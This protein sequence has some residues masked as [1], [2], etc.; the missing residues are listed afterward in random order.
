MGGIFSSSKSSSVKEI[1]DLQD[2]EVKELKKRLVHLDSIDRNGDGIITREELSQWMKQQKTDMDY[3][4]RKVEDQ[5][6]AKYQK[7]LIDKDNEIKE[8]SR[9]VQ[10]LKNIN[11]MLETQKSKVIENYAVSGGGKPR[12]LVK[13]KSRLDEVSK[14]RVDEFVEKI[15]ADENVN[16]KYLPDF[17]ERQIY[18]NVF[19]LMINLLDNVLETTTIS[20]LG[21][22]MTIDIDPVTEEATIEECQEDKNEDD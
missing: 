7:E 20:F 21:H 10:A 12:E 19:N 11:K 17:V 15:L 3:F 6:S 9:Q 22:K 8:L 18:K 4:Q 16:I 14:K 13:R 1:K 5:I 2:D